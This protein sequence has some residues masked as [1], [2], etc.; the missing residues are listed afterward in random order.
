MTLFSLAEIGERGLIVHEE[1]KYFVANEVDWRKLPAY[2]ISSAPAVEQLVNVKAAFA[3]LGDSIF[4]DLDALATLGT[5]VGS[6]A[7]KNGPIPEKRYDFSGLPAKSIVVR[8]SSSLFVV[9][10]EATQPIDAILSGDA[11]VLV[12]RGAVFAAIP[13]NTVPHGTFC[14]LVNFSGVTKG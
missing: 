12:N 11:R 1:G 14:V 4:V 6:E 3:T 2:S 5:T 10:R 8:E 9:P 13:T 7:V